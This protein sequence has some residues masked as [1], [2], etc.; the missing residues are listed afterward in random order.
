MEIVVGEFGAALLGLLGGSLYSRMD[1]GIIDLYFYCF[2][3]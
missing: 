1:D 2:V 3:V